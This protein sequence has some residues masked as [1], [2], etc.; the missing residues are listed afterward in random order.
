M[1][2][3]D[4]LSMLPR[5]HLTVVRVREISLA[6]YSLSAYF[7]VEN[8]F[9]IAYERAKKTNVKL[10]TSFFSFFFS[11]I[12]NPAVEMLSLKADLRDQVLLE[13][14]VRHLQVQRAE[15]IQRHLYVWI[16][17]PRQVSIGRNILLC[18]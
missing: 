7:G 12:S 18:L 13:M 10:A 4:T 2:K 9:K 8:H 16:L 5:K 3:F 11:S 6:F 15:G 1:L 14:A 17:G